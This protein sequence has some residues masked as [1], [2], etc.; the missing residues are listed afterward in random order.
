MIATACGRLGFDASPAPEPERRW[1]HARTSGLATCAITDAG[2]LWCWGSGAAGNLGNGAAVVQPVARVGS[3]TDW[4]DVA[5]GRVV[6]CG[7]R[8]GD[9]LWCWGTN[10]LGAIP[11]AQPGELVASPTQIAGAWR[12]VR[13]AGKH[14]CAIDA[15]GV[16]SCWGEGAGGTLGNGQVGD[17]AQPTPVSAVGTNRWTALDLSAGTTC[18]PAGFAFRAASFATMRVGPPPI[19]MLIRVA[20]RTCSRIRVARTAR[21]LVR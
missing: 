20:A 1:V 7:L 2:E 14:A 13:A 15:S 9:S 6:T 17:R 12:A 8:S 4:I 18:V 3:A 11:G 16:L 21:S 10:E 19:D 5:V